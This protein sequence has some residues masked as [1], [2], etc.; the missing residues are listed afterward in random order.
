M[1][2]FSFKLHASGVVID[3]FE[4]T[5]LP[6]ADAAY[7]EACQLARELMRNRERQTWHWRFE[8]CDSDGNV[9]STLLFVDVDPTLDALDWRTREQVRRSSELSAEGERTLAKCRATILRSRAITAQLHGK[10]YLAAEHGHR[11]V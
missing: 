8:T 9:L 4:G 6:D 2:V 3:D 10:P 11:L 7:E 5:C 1:P